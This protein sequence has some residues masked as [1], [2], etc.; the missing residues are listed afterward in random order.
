MAAFHK[1][2][3]FR[4]AEGCCICKAKSSSSRFT[5][6]GKYE[7]QFRSCFLLDEERDGDICNA[8]V[9]LVK[10][11]KKLPKDTK[12]NWA[13]TV[14]SRAG[15]GVKGSGKQKKKCE[16]IGHEIFKKIRKK[17]RKI[18]K[19]RNIDNNLERSR[20]ESY[21]GQ[22]Q[23]S[24]S[25]DN[26]VSHFFPEHYW[27]RKL[28]CCGVTYIGMLGEVMIDRRLFRPCQKSTPKSIFERLIEQ[29]L[30]SITSDSFTLKNDDKSVIEKVDEGFSE[31]N[32][33][34]FSD[35]ASSTTGPGSPDS[36][37]LVLE[38]D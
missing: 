7:D 34:S 18:N 13:H 6:S 15:P 19:V 1:P 14:D 16:E 33:E 17:K 31:K 37:Q 11:Y 22:E 25:E 10:R 35:K 3:I 21:K 12:K 8:C 29:E 9:L 27:Q 2:K 26:I 36:C 23:K 30:K 5:D 20:T 24:R 32:D 28:T 4:S 38:D